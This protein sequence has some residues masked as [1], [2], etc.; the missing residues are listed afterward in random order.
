[1]AGTGVNVKLGVS[2]LNDFKR[3]LKGAKAEV[4]ALKKALELNE[5]QYGLYGDEAQYMTNK[6]SLLNQEIDA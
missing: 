5:K 3:D 4:D 2:G 6:V 1:M